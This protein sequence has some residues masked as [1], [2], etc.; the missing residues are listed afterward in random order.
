MT[1]EI[2]GDQ[3]RAL[4]A[5]VATLRPGWDSPG[6]LA[7]LRD[8]RTKGTPDQVAHAATTAAMDPANRT[9]AVIALDGAHWAGVRPVETRGA[10]YDRCT[11]PGHEQWPAWHCAG[12][13]ADARA[14]DAPRE[15]TPEPVDV[16][17][18][19]EL[20]RTALHAALTHQEKP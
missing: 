13:R 5:L 18:G 11:V 9:P 17:P 3:A 14:A 6:V 4:A 1:N 16:G 8:A 12:C 7:A 10:N 15:T 19:P 2:N 20:A